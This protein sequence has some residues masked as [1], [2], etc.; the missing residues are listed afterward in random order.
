MKPE[1]SLPHSQET[2]TGPYPE[3]N[4]SSPHCPILS[5]RDP[6]YVIYVR[7]KF[8]KPETLTKQP[9]KQES[10]YDGNH[11]SYNNQQNYTTIKKDR[12]ALRV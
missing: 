2:S 6:L 10:S 8:Q 1:V 12:N 11:L 5:P 4:Q 3:P 7:T 9:E